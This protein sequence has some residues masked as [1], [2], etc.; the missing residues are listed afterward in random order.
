VHRVKRLRAIRA[1]DANHIHHRIATG[2]GTGH[3]RLGRLQR[4]QR[5]IRTPR[6]FAHGH[7]I[8]AQAFASVAPN[9]SAR[10]KYR[11]FHPRIFHTKGGNATFLF[12]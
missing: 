11:N 4:V 7:A 9:E 1:L 6:Q 3:F 2:D 12:F 5:R 10:S 8:R